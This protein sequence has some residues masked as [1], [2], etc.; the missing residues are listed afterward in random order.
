MTRA[1]L[2]KLS[3]KLGLSGASRGQSLGE[4]Q[5]SFHDHHLCP[6]VSL[7]LLVCLSA[8]FCCSRRP[9]RF[10]FNPWTTRY[11]G[12]GVVFFSED[13]AVGFCLPEFKR[14]LG[15]E[16]VRTTR[17]LPNGVV[18]L[19]PSKA[20]LCTKTRTPTE[21]AG[22]SS[23]EPTAA[24]RKGKT[25]AIRVGSPRAMDSENNK[26]IPKYTIQRERFGV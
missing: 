22:T 23:T 26:Q 15:N 10:F 4:R 18:Q 5:L 12:H 2:S 21:V 14:T 13:G 1:V 24:R 3:S 7:C 17:D 19:T 9:C 25:R 16:K 11:P 20:P 6:Q 8:F